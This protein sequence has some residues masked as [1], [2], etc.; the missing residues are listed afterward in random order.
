MLH[1]DSAAQ[2]PLV[3]ITEDFA[4]DVAKFC[5]AV[6]PAEQRNA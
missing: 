5:L 2:K 6:V 4:V 3:K 1:T